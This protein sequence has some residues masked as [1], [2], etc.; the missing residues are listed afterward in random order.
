[1]ADSVLKFNFLVGKNEVPAAADKNA[2]ALTKLA[3][4]TASFGKVAAVALGGAA[5]AA[6]GMAAAGVVMGVKTAASLEQAQ[7]GFSTLLGSSRKAGDYLTKLKAFAAATPFELNGLI[8]S[9][10]ALLG[11]GVN[12]NDAMKILQSFGDTA[13]AVGID[14]AAFQRIMVATSQ[15]IGAGKFQTQDLNQ[16]MNNGI[17]I[18]TILSRAMGKPIPEIRKLASSGKLLS[19]DVLPVLEKQMG[20]DYGGAMSRQSQTLAGLWSTLMDTLNLGLASV[21]QPLLPTLKTLATDGINFLGAAFK[22]LPAKI[23]T[24]ITWFGNVRDYVAKNV[25]PGIRTALGHIGD[26][27]PRIDWGKVIGDAKGVAGRVAGVL[28]PASGAVLA[29]AQHWGGRILDGITTGLHAGNWGPLGKTLGDGLATALGALG[30]GSNQLVAA[31]AGWVGSV[32]WLAIGKTFG[33]HAIGFAIGFVNGLGADLVDVARN[34]PMDLAIFVATFVGVGKL[35]TMFGPLRS[36][37]EHLPL[38]T[39]VT[40][41]FD[42]TAVPV[43]NAIGRFFKFIGSGVLQGFRDVFPGTEGALSRF[44]RGLET[45]IGGR[46]LYWIDGGKELVKGLSIGIGQRLGFVL[47]DIG[48]RIVSMLSPFTHAST[49]LVGAGAAAVGGLIYGT[50]SLAVAVGR[51]MGTI[52]SAVIAP[53]KSAGSWLISTGSAVIG[54]LITGWQ[55]VAPHLAIALGHT[56]DGLK[57][58]FAP[59]YKWLIK[60]GIDLIE[61]FVA[62]A[63]SMFRTVTST[64]GGFIGSR[65]L[66]PFGNAAGWL[67]GAGSRVIKGLV[68]GITSMFRAVTTTVGGFISVR[69]MGPFSSAS[70]WLVSKGAVL[71]SGLTRGIGSMLAVVGRAASSVISRVTSPFRSAASWLVGTGRDLISGLYHGIG[72]A[73]GAVKDWVSSH[74]TGPIIKAVKWFFGIQSPSRVFAGIGGHLVGGLLQGMLRANPS[75]IIGKVFGGM[76]SALKAI[77]GKGLVGLGDLTG[78]AMSALGMAGTMPV[79]GGGNGTNMQIG[80]RMNAAMG[81]GGYWPQLAAL[82]NRES[83]WNQYARNASSG[84]YGIPQALPASKLATA[85]ADWRT[86]PTTQIRWGLGYIG[87]RYQNPGN[88]WAHEQQYGWYDSGGIARGAGLIAKGPQPERV[89]SPRQTVAFEQLVPLLG[90]TSGAVVH[91]HFDIRLDASAAAFEDKIVRTIDH[92]TRV[93]RLPRR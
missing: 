85:G 70:S 55:T 23:E 53:F 19:S 3:S 49:W 91:N 14:Q 75:A 44:F 22:A 78:K 30:K 76:P 2:G 56:I 71:V 72:S 38:G 88:A 35:A 11:V 50:V 57:Y 77:V 46:V 51:A 28:L 12:A 60:P 36:L 8:D 9:S 16:I 64:V 63:A 29:A 43:A 39:W 61:G 81:W 58:L 52:A 1:M 74:I 5:V 69:I 13:S 31:V 40:G 18:W 59:A 37:I 42:H 86:N 67:V 82:W 87:G 47:K 80:Q 7:I 45:E 26:R 21:L 92:A 6:G 62:G 83:G 41:L 25:L 48:Q 73:L 4:R 89:L 93:G 34:H 32:D 84:A 24:A 33:G 79:S 27:L 54:G 20:K 10:R 17:P 90:R 68:S 66:G 15:A 65:I